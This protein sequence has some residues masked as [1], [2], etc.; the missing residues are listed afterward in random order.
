LRTKAKALQEAG[1]DRGVPQPELARRTGMT[2]TEVRNTVRGMAQRP[3]SLEAEEIDPKTSTDV[4]SSAFTRTVLDSVVDVIRDLPAEQ[5]T[6]IA[7]HYWRGLQLQEVARTMAITESRA[8]QLHA[9]A[10]L[11]VHEVMKTAAENEAG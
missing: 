10:V 5:Q 1:Q 7:L 2:L 11:T 4:E 6:V 9:K 8:S 3:V